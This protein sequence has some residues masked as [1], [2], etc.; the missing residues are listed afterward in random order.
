MENGYLA[1]IEMENLTP[2][3]EQPVNRD[4]VKRKRRRIVI[5]SVIGIAVLTLIT[6]NYGFY[7]IY[8]INREKRELEQEI[9]RLKLEQEELI[10]DR[11]RLKNDLI[12]IEKVARE[13]YSM[14]REGEQVYQVIPKKEEKKE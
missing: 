1:A 2:D 11:E 5:W 8:K 14:V 10:R 4:V 9:A 6:G 12:Y 3:I 7:Q 13:K